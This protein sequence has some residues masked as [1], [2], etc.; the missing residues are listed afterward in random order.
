[1]RSDMKIYRMVV[2]ALLCAIGILIPL[3]SPAKITLEP[4]SFTLASHLPIFLAIF[5]SPVTAVAVCLGTTLGFFLSMPLVVA[6]RAL[7]HLLFAIVGA[8]W[9]KKFP[10]T[11]QKP[12]S[13]VL[14][15]LVTACIHAIGEVLVVLPFYMGNQMSSG[16]YTKGFFISVILLV[17]VGTVVH[18]SID[19]LLALI[20]WKPLKKVL[21]HN[22]S[23]VTAER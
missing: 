8:I 21:R 13:S 9:L 16:Y 3:V 23:A 15:C 19:Y 20:V 4:A 12:A 22:H 1:M 7:S 18:I 17:G 10:N 5:I 11:L 6:V 14:F 2:A